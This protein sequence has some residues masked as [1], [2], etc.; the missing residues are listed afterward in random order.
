MKKTQQ[1]TRNNF[2]N[3]KMFNYLFR[4]FQDV[5][6]SPNLP[7]EINEIQLLKDGSWIVHGSNSEMRAV[8]TPTKPSHKVEVIN[9]D[10]GLYLEN[11]MHN[12][13]I[14]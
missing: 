1:N 10:I 3:D 9:D 5:L 11:M 13:F 7:S 14:I 6:S 2:M 8:D 12:R 4:Y